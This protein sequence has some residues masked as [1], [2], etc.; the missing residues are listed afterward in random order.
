MNWISDISLRFLPRFYNAYVTYGQETFGRLI[1]SFCFADIRCRLLPC[2]FFIMMDDVEH[3][4][5]T[6]WFRPKRS[7]VIE[8]FAVVFHYFWNSLLWLQGQVSGHEK[9]PALQIGPLRYICLTSLQ[10]SCSTPRPHKILWLYSSTVY[11]HMVDFY[12]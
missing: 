4:N 1:D 3:F 8:P 9:S 12:P 6:V 5:N 2:C 10:G 7:T 11:C